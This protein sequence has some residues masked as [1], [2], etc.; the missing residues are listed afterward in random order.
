[1]PSQVNFTIIQAHISFWLKSVGG[2]L[3]A[4]SRRIGI[5]EAGA[6]ADAAAAAAAAAAAPTESERIAAIKTLRATA[7]AQVQEQTKALKQ[8][9]KKR[10]HCRAAAR[11]LSEADLRSIIADKAAAAAAAAPAPVAAEG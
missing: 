5:M 1:M 6:V 3:A 2:D 4:R 8:A 7:R 11:F 10:K 9:L